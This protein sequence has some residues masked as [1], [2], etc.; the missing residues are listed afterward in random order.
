MQA[1]HQLAAALTL[2]LAALPAAAQSANA[3]TPKACSIHATTFH[4]WSA[5][6]MA[7]Q[8]VQLVFVPEL[9]GRLMQVTFAGHAYLFDNPEYEGKHITPEQ[10]KGRWINWA[11][12][13][14][15]PLPEGND[16]EQHWTGAST[17]LD[18]A[19]YQFSV[20]AQGERC[21]VRLDGPP[22]PPTGLQYSREISIGNDSPE[23]FFH[24]ITKNYT[25]HSISWSVQSVS[26][27][28]LADPA[29]PNGYNHNFWA[30]TP[31][32]PNS[33]YLLGYHVRDGLANDPSF[34][35]KDSLFRLHWKYIESEVWVDSVGGWV[36]V[37]DG[38]SNYT[39]VEKSKYIRNSEYPSKASV[40]FYKNGPT[41]ELDSAGIPHISRLDQKQ[42]PYYM[43]AEINSPM[44]DLGPGES[45]TFDTQWF[46][47]RM[48]PEVNTV[49]DSGAVSKP[50]TI[51]R[52]GSELQLTGQFG[53][54]FPGTLEA[55]LYDRGGEERDH[56]TIQSVTPNDLIDLHK[57]IPAS[58]H[59][60]RVSL[61]LVDGNHVDRGALGEA[62]VA[63]TQE[64]D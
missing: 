55:H 64:E 52:N 26:Q 33:G 14:I 16:D 48:T 59:I 12:D 23:I 61:H 38:A 60:V 43:E 47:C 44:A 6:E 19:A 41:V 32:N 58:D 5:Q 11:G 49:T 3:E 36:A 9:G 15:W 1:H 7:N 54:F 34:S 57:S 8:W 46:P 35:V 42:T 21:T 50:L 20:V 13:K 45:Y 2:T 10:A 31:A 63:G 56:V 51:A 62:F 53:V 24:A 30:I 37:V 39:M 25:G 4:G 17:P 18:D 28:N 27:Y 29:Q 22:D 40:I